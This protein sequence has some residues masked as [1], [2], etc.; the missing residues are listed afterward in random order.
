MMIVK[1]FLLYPS[2]GHI[3][4]K[5]AEESIDI[6]FKILKEVRFPINVLS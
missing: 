3:T 2:P 6:Q 1:F 5:Q 4:T